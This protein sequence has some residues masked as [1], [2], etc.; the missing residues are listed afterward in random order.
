VYVVARESAGIGDPHSLLVFAAVHAPPV[1]DT[2]L[3][4]VN[5]GG[6]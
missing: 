3:L 4:D 5:T 2:P 1:T 6:R